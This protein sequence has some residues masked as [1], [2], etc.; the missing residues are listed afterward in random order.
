MINI[1]QVKQ[2]LRPINARM[3]KEQISAMEKEV[4]FFASRLSFERKQSEKADLER[5]SQLRTMF[6][7]WK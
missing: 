3:S 6:N 1:D 7:F 2:D 5:K 4:N